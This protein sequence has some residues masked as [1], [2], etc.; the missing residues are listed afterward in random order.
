M[1]NTLFNKLDSLE[2]KYIQF[3]IDVCKIES[4]TEYKEGVD[5]VGQYFIEKAEA[6]G[7]K[8]EVLK[9][10][11]SGDC[12]CITMNPEAQARPVVF[13]S[14][15]DT[16]HPVGFF[17]EEIVTCDE[18]KIY[19]PG[20]TDCK[21]GAVAAFYAMEVLKNIG[22]TK[23][24]V[25][26]I[27]QSDEENSSRTSNK[28]TI[29][30]MCEKSKDAIAF[31]NGEGYAPGKAVVSRKGISKYEFEVTGKS[32]HASGCFNGASAIHEAAYKIVELEKWKDP[33]G[34]TCNCG[35]IQ[36]GTAENTVPGKCVFTADFRFSNGEEMRAVDAFVEAVT[37]KVF[38]EGTECK[39]T[40]KSRRCAMPRTERNLE[41]LDKI[42]HVFE[43]AGLPVLE[44]SFRRSGSDAA[45][46]TEYG[47]PCLD[48]FGVEGFGIH[49]R[50]EF[51]YLDSLKESAKRMAV[52]ACGI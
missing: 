29:R 3:W 48:G 16:V 28:G 46:V 42:N 22:F 50:E 14:H 37:A 19:G 39:V 41:L 31:L 33:E 23:R 49:R 35:L 20:A 7:W 45:D 11:V 12:V 13:S 30:F 38:V 21:G 1:Y 52:I 25:M 18:E 2:K 4:P 36:G 6:Y 27:L 51:A 44:E 5:R 47:V 17:G 9:Q 15:M 24:P 8:V 32:V 10:P 34:I 43:E 26:L 40:L